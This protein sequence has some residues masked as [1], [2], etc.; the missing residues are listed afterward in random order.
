MIEYIITGFQYAIPFLIVFFMF[1]AFKYYY[2]KQPLKGS[3]VDGLSFGILLTGWQTLHIYRYQLDY[4]LII[5]GYIVIGIILFLLQTVNKYYV[6]KA[7]LEE[8]IIDGLVMGIGMIITFW[9]LGFLYG[10]VFK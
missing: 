1:T 6:H 3:I 8:S 9:I 7:P 10:L 2:K 5:I 4:Q